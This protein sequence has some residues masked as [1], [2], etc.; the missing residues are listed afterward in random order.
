[1]ISGGIQSDMLLASI[2]MFPNPHCDTTT[3]SN[4]HPISLFKFD[5]KLFVKI[6]A[7][8]LN[9][10]IVKIAGKDQVGLIPIRQASDN[11]RRPSK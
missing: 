4:F 3:W 10:E 8:R 9:T 7:S 1:M 6:L 11:I 5:A 2:C